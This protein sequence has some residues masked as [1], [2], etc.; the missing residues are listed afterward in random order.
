MKRTILAAAL[1][2]A[3]VIGFAAPPAHAAS[4]DADVARLSA[5]LEQLSADPVLGQYAIAQQ[6]L[7]RNAIG[8]LQNAG[9]SEREHALFMAEQRVELA[10]ASAQV[11]ADRAKLDQLQREHDQI[12]LEASQADAAAARAELARQRLQYEAAVQQ[13]QMLQEQGAQASQ[14]A[15]QAQAE[16]AQARK[17]AAAQ[18]RAAALARKEAKLAMAA[19]QALQGGGSDNASSAGGGGHA[20][21]MHLSSASFGSGSD[22]LTESGRRRLA[23][24]ARAHASQRIVIEPRG[25]ADSRVLAGRRAV[26]VEAALEAAGAANVSIRPVGRASSGA[27]VEVRAEK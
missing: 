27:E 5:Q 12:M 21:S 4:K 26:A 3:L 7:A 14:Q 13:A 24:F 19:T 25:A 2:G 17:L 18:A 1:A 15:Q 23:D 20:A 16:A 8:D 11:D 9:R 10:R 22:N 6:T